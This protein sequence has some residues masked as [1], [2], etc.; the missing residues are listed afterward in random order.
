M[1]AGLLQL[2][3]GTVVLVDETVLDEGQLV[4]PGV[5]NFQAL[6]DLIQNQTLKYEFPYSQYEFD[7]DLN[8]LTLSNTKSML[9]VSFFFFFFNELCHLKKFTRTIEPLLD[10]SRHGSVH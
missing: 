5:R 8:I 3:D 1:E 4:D 7:T 10:S 6:H 9:P 2:I